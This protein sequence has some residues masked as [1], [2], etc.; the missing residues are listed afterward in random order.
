[1]CIRDSPN[2]MF[3]PQ[4]LKGAVDAYIAS[5]GLVSQDNKAAVRLDDLLFSLVN[6]STKKENAVRTILR[7][8]IMPPILKGNFAEHFLVLKPDGTPLFK[9]PVK[10]DIP[11]I[12]IVTEMKIG[13]KVV[14]K[15]SNFEKFQVDADELAEAL[16]KKCSGSTTIGE[17]TTSPKTTEVTVQGPH[18]PAVI[19]L[20][21]QLAIPTKWINFVNKLKKSKK[22]K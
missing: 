9:H 17:T 3:S 12:Q 8:Q 5:K 19:E 16:R 6:R 15:V 18:G 4:E 1:M 13:R 21:N 22:R 2:S 14:T 20:L 10:G 11:Q 7:A